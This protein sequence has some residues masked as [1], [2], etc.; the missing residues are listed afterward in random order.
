[1]YAGTTLNST[2]EPGR[3]IEEFKKLSVKPKG[4]L[5]V[6]PFLASLFDEVDLACNTGL[7]WTL[8]TRT[9]LPLHNN[10]THLYRAMINVSDDTPNALSLSLDSHP[11]HQNLR[12]G[13]FWAR[14]NTN[15]AL[16]GPGHDSNEVDNHSLYAHSAHSSDFE[17]NYDSEYNTDY[18]AHP[19]H[20][21]NEDEDLINPYDGFF[22]QN[23]IS[24]NL[25]RRESS[26]QPLSSSI[27]KLKTEIEDRLTLNPPL[28]WLPH[29]LEPPTLVVPD[30]PHLALS[31]E[32]EEIVRVSVRDSL[33]PITDF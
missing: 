24:S 17:L 6:F 21:A 18:S 16:Y 12:R 13:L 23:S 1:M 3:S 11:T 14:Q 4:M 33:Q 28:G 9:A 7:I 10:T 19:N 31:K 8:G 20:F 26:A 32:H 29:A 15:L 2:S 30:H 22:S 27:D 25:L 5:F